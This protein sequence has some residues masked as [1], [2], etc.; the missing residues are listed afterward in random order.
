MKAVGNL[1]VEV[2]ERKGKGNLSVIRVL[3]RTFN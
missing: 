2:Y 1:R 3:K